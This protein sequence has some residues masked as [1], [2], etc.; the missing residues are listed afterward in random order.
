MGTLSKLTVGFAAAAALTVGAYQAFKV[1]TPEDCAVEAS[2]ARGK[3]FEHAN[4]SDAKS[5]EETA[6][7]YGKSASEWFKATGEQAKCTADYFRD[8]GKTIKLQAFG[9]TYAIRLP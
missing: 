6:K 2:A 5:L 9:K 1:K 4:K 8:D 3:A 7:N